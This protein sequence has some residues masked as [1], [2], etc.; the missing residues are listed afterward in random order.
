MASLVTAGFAR[1]AA[2]SGVRFL[3]VG[4]LS[5]AADAGALFVLHGLLHVWLP[6]ATTLAFAAAFVVNFGLNRLWSFR[7]SGQVGRQVWRYVWLVLANLAVTV[8]LVQGLVWAGIPYLG[9]KVATTGLLSVINYL[10]SRRWI[11]V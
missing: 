10:V 11:F 9:A 1:L 6:A 4:M 7:T 5:F 2:G 8:V 3:A